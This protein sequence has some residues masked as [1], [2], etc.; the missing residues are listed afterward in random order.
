MVQMSV[1]SSRGS[2]TSK[3]HS[4]ITPSPSSFLYRG[5]WTMNTIN[6]SATEMKRGE[7]LFKVYLR[8]AVS[9][10]LSSSC[11]PTLESFGTLARELAREREGL[12]KFPLM[13]IDSRLSPPRE[14]APRLLLSTVF[15]PFFLS[16]FPFLFFF[17][18]RGFSLRFEFGESREVERV[19]LFFFFFEVEATSVS[20]GFARLVMRDRVQEVEE[21]WFALWLFMVE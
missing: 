7:F 2:W 10:V 19:F 15:L 16:F 13:P 4:W 1:F 8:V 3:D 20:R 9:R 21:N 5:C 12:L 6:Q 11:T 17:L 14:E 18:L